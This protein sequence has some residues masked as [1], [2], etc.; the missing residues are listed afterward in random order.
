MRALHLPD[1]GH[2]RLHRL[3]RHLPVRQ[4]LCLLPLVLVAILAVRN[5]SV[6]LD[7]FGQLRTASWPWLLAA[8]GATCLTW[9]AA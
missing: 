6:L 7:G 2:G 5:R 8:A 3:A 1:L 9:V 4:L